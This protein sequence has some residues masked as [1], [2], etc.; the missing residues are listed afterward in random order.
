MFH[1]SGEIMKA[2]DIDALSRSY[3]TEGVIQGENMLSFLPLHKSV[4]ERSG[5]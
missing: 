3:L 5:C 1:I 2:C 4:V